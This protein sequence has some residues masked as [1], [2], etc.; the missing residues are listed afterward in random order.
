MNLFIYDRRITKPISYAAGLGAR[1]CCREFIAHGWLID[2]SPWWRIGLLSRGETFWSWSCSSWSR[3]DRWDWFVD[4]VCMHVLQQMQAKVIEWLVATF[5]CILAK[6]SRAPPPYIWQPPAVE[7][8][9]PACTYARIQLR[10][11]E[12]PGRQ[13]RTTQP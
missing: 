13:H 7:P 5:R 3:P 9:T 12:R 6:I 2:W 10:L 1:R 8:D 4:L 11:L